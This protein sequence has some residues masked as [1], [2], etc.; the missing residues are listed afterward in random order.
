MRAVSHYRTTDFITVLA[1]KSFSRRSPMMRL[2]TNLHSNSCLYLLSILTKNSIFHYPCATSDPNQIRCKQFVD[3]RRPNYY[4]IKSTV[5]D[6]YSPFQYARRSASTIGLGPSS[7]YP[8][9]L[10]GDYLSDKKPSS[11]HRNREEVNRPPTSGSDKYSQKGARFFNEPVSKSP[12]LKRPEESPVNAAAKTLEK[13][14]ETVTRPKS[15]RQ[16]ILKSRIINDL[17]YALIL[18]T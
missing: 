11:S 2:T 5:Q 18:A 4:L 16:M 13:E 12:I 10:K 14:Q 15:V 9:P 1:I 8:K 6:I 3:G 17:E 7:S